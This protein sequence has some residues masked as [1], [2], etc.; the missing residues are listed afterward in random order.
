[1]LIKSIFVI[2]IAAVALFFAVDSLVAVFGNLH[3]V[4]VLALILGAILQ[5]LCSIKLNFKAFGKQSGASVEDEGAPGEM[6]PGTLYVGNLAYTVSEKEVR[7]LFEQFGEVSSVRLMRD[8][9]SGRLRGFGFVEMIP[10]EAQK[11]VAAVSGNEF[12]GRKL[13]VNFA[14]DK[15]R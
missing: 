4:V 14:N 1:M 3:V 2:F 8:R 15:K 13:K 6:S 12:M 5:A 11:A 9:N 7:K 10:A